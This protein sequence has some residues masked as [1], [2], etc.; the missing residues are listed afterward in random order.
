MPVRAVVRQLKSGALPPPKCQQ[1]DCRVCARGKYRKRFD[2]SLTTESRPGKL[3]AD[4][5]G[6]VDVQS[7]QGH[8]YFLTVVDEYSRFTY[9][10]PLRSKGEASEA[11]LHYV[12]CFE[13]QTGRTVRALHTDGGGEFVKARKALKSQGVKCTHTTAYTAASNGLA[14]RTHG[15][16]LAL[17][18]SCLLQSKL[19]LKYWAYAVEH[20]TTCKNVVTHSTT[21]RVPYDDL[22]GTRSPDLTYLRPFGCRVQ[23]HPVKPTLKTFKPRLEE[24]INLGHED[25]GIYWVL[26]ETGVVRTKHVRMLETEFPGTA[27]TL[28]DKEQEAIERDFEAKE[29]QSETSSVAD[30]D[31]SSESSQSGGEE[32]PDNDDDNLVTYTPAKPSRHGET[33][34]EE[35]DDPDDSSSDGDD[36]DDNAG[37]S[38]PSDGEFVDA[39]DGGDDDDDDGQAPT[40]TPRRPGLRPAKDVNY[41]YRA[42]PSHLIDDTPKLSDALKSAEKSLWLKAI[43]E[44]FKTLTDSETYEPCNGPE[45]GDLVLPAGIILKL[46]RD[47]YGH[48]VRRRGRLVARGCY[49]SDGESYV[50]LYTPVACIELARVLLAVS[51]QC[52]WDIE[53]VD[54]KGAF[55]YARLPESDKIVIRLPKIDGVK[56]AN[57]QYVR[58]RRSL[59]GLRQAPKLWYAHL[60]R[61]LR[62]IGLSEALS[63]NCLFKSTSGDPVFVL[64]Y[65]DDLLIVGAPAGVA[66]VKAELAKQ[67]TTTELGPCTHFLGIAVDRSSKGLF[68]S[69]KPFTDKLVEYAGLKSAKPTPA[70]LPLSHCL[71]EKTA[72]PTDDEIDE[73]ATCPSAPCLGHYCTWLQE[74]ARTLPLPCPCWPSSRKSRRRDSGKP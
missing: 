72:E 56:A 36:D 29:V 66:R 9:T 8:K 62:K 47:K 46:K 55:L 57:G 71:Y 14:E 51:V 4:T 30:S 42:V 73:C 59:Y 68:L 35:E 24:G 38:S 2:G 43:E 50:E 65:F 37:E 44:E 41:V 63:T 32:P 20:V 1:T 16:I 27:P 22:Y 54:I 69:Q 5:K 74:A 17:A 28:E 67:F 58:L 40:T 7:T 13:K 33:D 23:Y 26:T 3:H 49:Q 31:T 45:P 11:L 21:G 61:A 25:G 64:V 10:C 12:K 52:D 34:D 53:H 39:Q 18:R 6:Q 60:A 48:P 19:P 15:T 70:P